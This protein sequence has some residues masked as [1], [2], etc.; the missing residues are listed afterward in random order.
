MAATVGAGVQDGEMVE[1]LAA[2]NALAVSGT[3]NVSFP[4][5]SEVFM[6]TDSL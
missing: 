6:V 4:I 5:H 3:S 1:T 2:R